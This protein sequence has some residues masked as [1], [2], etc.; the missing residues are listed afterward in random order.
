MG[1]LSA[2]RK[3]PARTASSVRLG[4]ALDAWGSELSPILAGDRG[5]RF[6]E[7][8]DEYGL[9]VGESTH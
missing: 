5:C 2:S 1:I 6:R 7:N 4:E 8:G 9:W 3:I